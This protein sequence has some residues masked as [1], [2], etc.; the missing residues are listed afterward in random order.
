MQ[1]PRARAVALSVRGLAGAHGPAST[2]SPGLGRT[3]LLTL[4]ARNLVAPSV[5]SQSPT[6]V[7]GAGGFPRRR[8]HT[9][10]L[11]PSSF[12]LPFLVISPPFFLPLAFPPYLP[13]SSAPVSNLESHRLCCQGGGSSSPAALGGFCTNEH[14]L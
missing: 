11:A 5:T 6:D 10:C 12:L 1:Q 7:G 9:A 3:V 4:R 13:H 14:H 8:V 2:L